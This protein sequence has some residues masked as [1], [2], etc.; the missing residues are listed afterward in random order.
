MIRP[1]SI[2]PALVLVA[3]TLAIAPAA[4]AAS[5]PDANVTSVDVIA[6]ADAPSVTVSS[7]I[8]LDVKEQVDAALGS[9]RITLQPRDLAELKRK[10]R[11]LL[12]EDEDF[13]ARMVRILDDLRSDELRLNVGFR[14]VEIESVDPIC[15]VD[16]AE[17]WELE[18]PAGVESSMAERAAEIYSERPVMFTFYL[19]RN[20]MTMTGFQ[21]ALNQVEAMVQELPNPEDHVAL[22]ISSIRQKTYVQLT[23]NKRKLL[24]TVRAIRADTRNPE[25]A[26]VP[27]D[28]VVRERMDAIFT[29][30][31]PQDVARVMARID[32]NDTVNA[33]ERLRFTIQAMENP[34]NQDEFRDRILVYFA[35]LNRGAFA[36]QLYLQAVGAEDRGFPL[37]QFELDRVTR[38]A[39]AV[40]V[41]LYTVQPHGQAPL[42]SFSRSRISAAANS[43]APRSAVSLGD[44][45]AIQGRTS[46]Q[47]MA[48]E[49]GGKWFV[50]GG[51]GV[52]N[53]MSGL[54]Q[55]LRCTMFVNFRI[56]DSLQRDEPLAVELAWGDSPIPRFFKTKT[57]GSFVISSKDTTE[58]HKL[59]AQV[60]GF[61][62]DSENTANLEALY[63]VVRPKKFEGKRMTIEIQHVVDVARAAPDFLRTA[64]G[65]AFEGSPGDIP[66]QFE[67]LVR[68]PADRIRRQKPIIVRA[69]GSDRVVL[70]RQHQIDFSD[71]DRTDPVTVIASARVGDTSYRSLRRDDMID[72]PTLRKDG[73][74]VTAILNEGPAPG[75]LFL[76]GWSREEAELLAVTQ[77]NKKAVFKLPY[78]LVGTPLVSRQV[79]GET[80]MT[81][82]AI[83]DPSRDL[84]AEMLVCRSDERA[85]TSYRVSVNGQ[86]MTKPGAMPASRGRE[87]MTGA[88]ELGEEAC[89]VHLE[90]VFSADQMARLDSLRGGDIHRYD[91]EVFQGKRK[92]YD[93]RR[94]F[95]LRRQG[96]E[97]TESGDPAMPDK[98][99][100]GD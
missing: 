23:Q 21:A 31:Q 99:Q 83:V 26:N 93:I 94:Y 64:D 87:E 86:V 12:A 66:W 13:A 70:V 80:D 82:V 59:L 37:A 63:T 81:D 60:T 11:R 3:I 71:Q 79:P 28:A 24:D 32:D 78:A 41:R 14:A 6:T 95:K 27:A 88:V 73:R 38:D 39:T 20:Y 40:G 89:R 58:V 51:A 36:G 57:Q 91:V 10:D 85:E 9:V 54:R 67:H 25:F 65:L 34:T 96:G 30:A 48:A 72:V 75:M 74:R 50:A 98:A 8:D 4:M 46:L 53:V 35:D 97:A 22:V 29:S 62:D 61:T 18:R 92:A 5:A 1:T 55:D 33:F 43:G 45:A 69:N 19:D 49:T 44:Q 52:Q 56:P 68:M 100:A 2:I 42:A 76:Q 17:T 16:L 47:A 84:Y 77:K 90:P 7:P 15:S